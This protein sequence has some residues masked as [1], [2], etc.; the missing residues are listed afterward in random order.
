MKFALVD[1]YRYWWPV[2]VNVPDTAN[3]GKF[4]HQNLKIE[5]EAEPRDEAIARIEKIDAL[6]VDERADH[7]FDELRRLVT[8]WD[9]VTLADGITPLPFTAEAFE[10]AIQ[11]SWFR[12]GVYRAYADSISGDKARLGN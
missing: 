6:P 3:P 9:E 12:I 7:E 2:T 1:S 4:L 8:N 5:F 11:F 10:K